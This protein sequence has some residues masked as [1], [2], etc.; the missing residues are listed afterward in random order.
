MKMKTWM[1]EAAFDIPDATVV[2]KVFMIKITPNKNLESFVMM[3]LFL[4]Q[5]WFIFFNWFLF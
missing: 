2:A 1:S 3:L 5:N 4:Y